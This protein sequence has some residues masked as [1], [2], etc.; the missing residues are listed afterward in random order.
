M[1]FNELRNSDITAIP[2][3]K[4]LIPMLKYL[5]KYWFAYP[6]KYELNKWDNDLNVHG[7][8]IICNELTKVRCFDIDDKNDPERMISKKFLSKLQKDHLEIYDKLYIEST[9]SNGHHLIFKASLSD[10]VKD[11]LKKTKIRNEEN[12]SLIDIFI[13]KKMVVVSPTDKYEPV[14]GRIFNLKW[15]TELEVLIL[16]DI[17]KSFDN[18]F[19]KQNNSRKRPNVIVPVAQINNNNDKEDDD[20]EQYNNSNDFIGL[21][22]DHKWK[23]Y[24][25][26]S[27]EI[28]FTRPGKENGTSAV[29]YQK[30]RLFHV[31]TSNSELEQDR[32]LTPFHL[33][34]IY[35]AKNN[36]KLAYKMLKEKSKKSIR[37]KTS[38]YL[39]FK[40]HLFKELAFEI[41]GQKIKN[42]YLFKMYLE[43]A[44]KNGFR[45]CYPQCTFIKLIRKDAKFYKWQAISIRGNIGDFTRFEKSEKLQKKYNFFTQ[46]ITIIEL[47]KHTNSKR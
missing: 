16:L 22:V 4:E 46:K 7:Y 9:K 37:I 32:T 15:L 33:F 41:E 40:E 39:S 20:I 28:H 24:K 42:S 14:S 44:E 11:S 23:I 10:A 3:T 1:I 12:Q 45:D 8:G 35:A 36:E 47:P 6:S 18:D 29:F 26:I 21:L 31:F 17:A 27:D 2:L 19:K 25:T 30:T 43:Y 38:G 34:I 5:R 13:D